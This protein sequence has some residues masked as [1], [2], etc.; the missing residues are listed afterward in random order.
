[1]KPFPHLL[2]QLPAIAVLSA[3]TLTAQAR[4]AQHDGGE[5]I[6]F[7]ADLDGDGRED[8]VVLDRASGGFRAA[9]QNAPAV[10]NW[11]AARATGIA[12]ITGT[13][14]GKWLTTARDSFAVVSPAANR[15]H[16]VA[17]AS[18]AA[19]PTLSP[20]F[21]PGLGPSSVASPDIG[22]ADNTAHSDLWLATVE[23][24]APAPVQLGM[25]RHDGNAFTSL[26]QTPSTRTPHGVRTLALK[27]GGTAW[28]CSIGTAA[29]QADRFSAISYAAGA[30]GSEVLATNIPAGSQWTSGRLSAGTLHHVMTWIPGQ[31]S[32]QSRSVVEA[33]PNVFSLAA[34]QLFPVGLPIGSLAIVESDLGPRLVVTHP[35]G[36]QAE[37]YSFDGIAP[38]ALVQQITPPLG[39]SL[40]GLLSLASG[41]FQLMQGPTGQG[42]TGTMTPFTAVDGV[43]EAGM[44]SVLPGIRPSAMRA[45]V[46]AFSSEP[47]VDPAARLLGRFNAPEWTSAPS[48]QGNQ[49]SVSRELFGGQTAGLGSKASQ[50]IGSVPVGTTF[51]LTNQVNQAIAVHSFDSGDGITAADVEILPAPGAKTQAVYLTFVATPASAP[52]FFRLGSGAWSQ[53]SP[54]DN[55]PIWSDSTVSYYTRH[56]IS[57]QP[58]AIRHAT[59][60]F[61]KSF[62]EMDSDGDGVPDFVEDH[63]HLNP[64][65]GNDGD[66]DG[67]SDLNEI[68]SGTTAN[69]VDDKPAENQRLEANVAFKLRVAPRPIDG[70]SGSRVGSTLDQRIDAFGLDGS[71]VA[72]GPTVHLATPGV[73]GPGLLSD[74]VV[75][76]DRQGM[77]SVLTQPIFPVVTASPDKQRGR[78]IAGLFFIPTPAAL[79]V[80]FTPGEVTVEAN[81]LAWVAAAQSA[82]NS[83]Q[84]P[85]VA[86]NWTEIDTLA[87]FLLEWKIEQI[88]VARGLPGLAA[89]RLT[90][91]GGR[92]GDAGRFS[93]DATALAALRLQASP[94]LPGYEPAVLFQAIKSAVEE[95]TLAGARA[96]ATAIY[97]TSSANSNAA[98]PGTYLPPFDVL[99]AFVRGTAL[100]APYDAEVAI[101]INALQSAQ[102]AMA[103]M[104]A[105]L[106]A[107]PVATYQLIVG[108]DSFS[109]GCH[110]LTDKLSAQTV[111]LFA[112]PGIPYQSTDGFSLIPG[113]ELQVTGYT[114]LVESCPGTSMEVISVA[115]LSFPA[116]PFVDTDKNLLADEWEWVFLLGGGNPFDDDDNDGIVNLQEY[117]DG[118]DPLDPKSKGA[119]ALIV[120]APQVFIVKDEADGVILS[121]EFP[122]QYAGAIQWTLQTS[123]DLISWQTQANAIIQQPAP[124]WHSI[125][126]PGVTLDHPD[127]FYR[128]IM[129]L[130]P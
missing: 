11:A 113:T 47:L 75:A 18:L 93:P 60:Q 50:I 110:T 53:W 123:P 54:I 28:V 19:Q 129:A 72:T 128:I 45:N 23:N 67:F 127:G 39:Q 62:F 40:T 36:T 46:F 74:S 97:R 120:K 30:A 100:P 66:G 3:I 64:L 73:S 20:V 118:T 121:W 6:Q 16:I 92:T 94:I 130:A 31:T 106:P 55:V 88:L 83:Q 115:V 63:L 10:W 104:L 77:I 61:D 87:A 15:C 95:P 117:L 56:P 101:A 91:F 125:A 35:D 29:G 122:A 111:N 79:Q 96:A 27:H 43:F 8:I 82:W 105:G 84:R 22:G 99:R 78:E 24:G 80:D 42:R 68:I 70:S 37:V 41:G 2:R 76:D 81:A 126:L 9:Y 33:P 17:A 52:V 109:G 48:L 116:S 38:P 114:D 26:L 12:E 58:S 59:Y 119:A 102:T 49:L 90:L 5:E 57:N 13:T 1:M 65:D 124:G 86:S 85:T 4:A 44:P 71:L 14:P 98:A 32:F 25:V 108:A 7:T 69:M 107:R 51:A 89:D 112:A 21:T 103:G 34:A